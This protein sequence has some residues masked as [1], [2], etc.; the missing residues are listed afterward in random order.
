MEDVVSPDSTDGQASTINSLWQDLSGRA[1]EEILLEWPPDVFAFTGTVL[2]RSEAF[3]FVVSPPPPWSWPPEPRSGWS[4]AILDGAAQWSAWAEGRQRSLPPIVE[5]NWQVV[6]KSGGT[7]LDDLGNAKAWVVCKALLTLH[8]VSDEACAGMGVTIDLNRR[9]GYRTRARGRELLARTGSLARLPVHRMRVL[10]KGRTA[11]AGISSRNLSRYVCLRGP[12]VKVVWD[13]V[14]LRHAGAVHQHLNI[15]LLP[16]PLQVHQREFQPVQ[17]SVQR[18]ENEPFGEFQFEPAE[19]FNFELLDRVLASALV[20]VK[21]VDVVLLP[22]LSIHKR[23]LERLDAVL[24]RH[25]VA[26]VAVGVRDDAQANA[27]TNWVRIGAYFGDSWWHY[28]QNKHHRWFLDESQI[29]QY[30]LAGELHPAVRWWEAMPVPRRS[31]QFIELGEGITFVAVICED[32]ARLDEVADLLRA[33]G[34]TLVVTPLLDGPQLS[35]RWTARYATVLAD[36]PGSAVLTLTS[37]GMVERSQ[38]AEK[39]KSSVVAL[40]KDSTRHLREISLDAG[41]QGVLLTVVVDR[42]RRR[43]PDGR[44]VPLD[45]VAD[46]FVASVRQIS[47]GAAS[48][49][50]GG[51]WPQ[52]VPAVLKTEELTILASWTEAVAEAMTASIGEV[53]AVVADASPGAHWREAFKIEEPGPELAKALRAV[54]DVLEAGAAGPDGLTMEHMRHTLERVRRDGDPH[55]LLA[56]KLLLTAL[57]ARLDR[58]ST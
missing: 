29:S 35:S 22:E 45:N 54:A 40:W 1:V 34:P 9:S 33:V 44:G 14:P 18:I 7:T 48:A 27:P 28:S 38:P 23:E 26:A 4:E 58:R 30:N 55:T 24:S 46:L 12:V 41:S 53:D 5:Q 25:E 43:S 42:A 10:P 11:L 39:P 37:Y 56:E 50:A 6:R 15:L 2:E 3:R 17:S 57:E 8:A 13:R 21:R 52:P 20:E 31:V 47:A 19:E 32:L 16:W 36:D 51:S 49:P